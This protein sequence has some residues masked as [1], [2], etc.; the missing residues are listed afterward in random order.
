MMYNNYNNLVLTFF[1]FTGLVHRVH[2]K[3][4]TEPTEKKKYKKPF[5]GPRQRPSD[6]NDL[7]QLFFYILT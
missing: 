1:Y 4:K 7:L 5:D 2:L 3:R 6:G